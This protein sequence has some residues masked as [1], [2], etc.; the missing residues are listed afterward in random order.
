MFAGGA[1]GGGGGGGVTGSRGGGEEGGVV[2]D[3]EGYA[4]AAGLSLGLVALGAGRGAVGLADLEL[5]RR[6]R[7]ARAAPTC[8]AHGARHGLWNR[9][10]RCCV[11]LVV[12][13]VD[14]WSWG[15]AGAR[16]GRQTRSLGAALGGCGAGGRSAWARVGGCA[17]V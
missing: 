8:L 12:V 13:V 9:M 6:L 14:C 16:W 10:G 1:F 3:R 17:H 2:T 4:L 15:R 5:E 11:G 7:C